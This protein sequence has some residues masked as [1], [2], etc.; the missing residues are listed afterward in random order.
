MGG[1]DWGDAPTRLGAVFAA[2]AAAAAAWTLKSQREQIDEQRDFIRQ[3]SLNLELERAELRAAAEDRKAAQARQIE[4]PTA[5]FMGPRPR[6]RTGRSRET[7]EELPEKGYLATN[8]RNTINAP[9]RAVQVYFGDLA[10]EPRARVSDTRTG[11]TEGEE[12]TPVRLI[13]VDKAYR[14]T[15]SLMT[16]REARIKPVS[17]RFTDDDGVRWVLHGTGKLE[18]VGEDQPGE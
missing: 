17:I 11:A 6:R 10:A 9:I 2:L 1:I 15:S 18:E 13:G 12:E 7:T 3:Q 14:Y 8:V 16:E 5:H 4:P